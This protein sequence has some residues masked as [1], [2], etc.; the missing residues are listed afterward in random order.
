MTYL[1]NRPSG[2]VFTRAIAVKPNSFDP[3]TRTFTAV[4][5]TDRPIRMRGG[6]MES[7]DLAAAQLPESLPLNLD[8]KS[9]V[10]STVGR[11]KNLRVVDGELTGDGVISRAS[12]CDWLADL[13]ED[14]TATSVS[15][16]YRAASVREG[17][18]RR[19]RTVVPQFLHAAIVSEPADDRAGIRS[20]DDD[21]D[22]FEPD[23]GQDITQRNARTR[24]LCRQLGLDSLIDR[25]IDERWGDS[26]IM[27]SY[28]E[29]S[30][31]NTIRSTRG[32]V[33]LDD[34]Q[35]FREAAR[36]SLVCRW[37]GQEPQ[38]PARELGSSDPEFFRRVLR[39][40]GQS[41]AG[42]SDQEVTTRALST[43]DYP[44]IA[45]QA[46]QIVTMRSFTSSVSPSAILAGTRNV[47]DF[48]TYTEGLL[49]WTTLGIDKVGQLGEYRHSFFSEDGESY[50]AETVGGRVDVSRQLNINAGARMGNLAE[51]QGRSLAAY[52][53]D[54][55]I[56]YITQATLAGPTMR[57]N[58]PVF[59]AGR[60]NIATLD[61]TTL[62]TV[63][64]TV[65][66]A[67]TAMA[68]RKGAGG[69]M[70]GAFPAYWLVPA[71][72]EG[73][74]VR[75]M[76]TINATQAADV[77]PLTG[78]LQVIVEPRLS[79]TS[80][81]Y[82]VCVPASFDG[83]VQVGLEGAPGPYVESRWGWE[84]DALQFKIR[85]DFGFGWLDWRSWTRMDHTEL[86]RWRRSPN[87]VVSSTT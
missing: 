79:S 15:V 30:G 44:L 41:V 40:S 5:A 50:F 14:G 29:R 23:D 81:S 65:L 49:D 43:S 35:I 3:A 10:R 84:V 47:P 83:L 6:F 46:F 69:V 19:S 55:R 20:R 18:D 7:L 1:R 9:D 12:H 53:S 66:L 21:D 34:P 52:V 86:G 72:F 11:V 77:N 33:T 37:T 82:L 24:S 17:A 68:K 13:V 70:I 71:E 76:A 22:S 58:N 38:G 27:D 59:Y 74:A 31:A 48:R 4:L 80:M 62:N 54:A 36:D 63:I 2:E 32:H 26:Q 39:H 64:D 78:R 25:A 73:T 51:M 75:A 45:G 61:T 67:R 42:L 28:L 8:H 56:G 87:F 85:Y 60:G 16:A 57:D